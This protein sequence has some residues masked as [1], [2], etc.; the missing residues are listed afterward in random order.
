MM[1]KFYLFLAVLGF[2]VP[3]FYTFAFSVETLE[4]WGGVTISNLLML[5]PEFYRTAT[6]N[7]VSTQLLADVL[8]ASVVFFIWMFGEGRRLGI[9]HLWVYPVITYSIAFSVAVPL[10]FYAREVAK[11]RAVSGGAATS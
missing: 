1:K 9:R 3:S 2:A 8:V 7:N 10:F 4:A 5:S 11:E 6:L